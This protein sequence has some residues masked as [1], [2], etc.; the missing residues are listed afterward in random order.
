LG[1]FPEQDFTNCPP[2]G[3][4]HLFCAYGSYVY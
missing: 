4:I 3:S 2:S 1:G